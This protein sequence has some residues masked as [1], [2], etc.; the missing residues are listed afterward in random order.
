M[1]G[2]Q[3]RPAWYLLGYDIRQPRRLKRV[4]RFLKGEAI[5]AQ[6]SLFLFHGTPASRD[7]LL[8]ELDQLI[9]PREDDV[10]LYPI[11]H[12]E[13][14]WLGG[15][16]PEAVAASRRGGKAAAGGWLGRIRRIW[17]SRGGKP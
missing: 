13:R 4:H 2:N 7:E 12:P 11:G 6:Q 16:I 3:Q 17:G 14:L 1:P 9:D 8:K 10:R 15:I 5:A